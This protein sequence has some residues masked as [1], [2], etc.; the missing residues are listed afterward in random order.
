MDEI[1]RSPWPTCGRAVTV[2]AVILAF[3]VL[4]GFTG[5]T[6]TRDVVVPKIV[7]R[8]PIRIPASL[9]TCKGEPRLNAALADKLRKDEDAGVDTSL[10][11][12]ELAAAGG[13][14]RAKLAAVI[15]YVE[16]QS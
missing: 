2:F 8:E 4:S 14:C 1:K 16:S 6:T 13:D 15:R 12:N 5:C 3:V 11:I 9:R 7:E 10:F